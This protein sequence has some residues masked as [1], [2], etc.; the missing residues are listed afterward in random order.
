M[1]S[2]RFLSHSL[3]AAIFGLGLTSCKT[4]AERWSPAGGEPEPPA[5]FRHSTSTDAAAVTSRGAWWKTYRDPE[6]NRLMN[7]VESNNPDVKSALA[8]VEQAYATL[9]IT[10]A[11]RFP[12]LSGSAS[13]TQV[14]DS[15]NNLRFVLEPLKYEQYR[16]AANA[17]WELD[18]WGRVRGNFQRDQLRAEATRAQYDDVLLSLRATLARQYFALHYAR[19]EKAILEEGVSVRQEALRL[20]ETRVAEGA[21][22]EL[23]ASRART[24]LESTRVQAAELDRTTGKLEH[25]IAVL[26]GVAPADFTASKSQV[27]IR[28]PDTPSGIPSQ[29]L[30][31]R[32]DLRVAERNLH[33]AAKQVG[34]QKVEFLPRITLTGSG[35][36]ASLRTDNLFASP[37]SV[38]RSVG[39]QVDIPLFQGGARKAAVARVEAAWR[40]AIEDYRSTL[41]TAVQEVDD[42]LLDLQ[43][44]QRQIV[45]QERAVDS[46][47]DTA[48]LS[49][50]RFEQGF[51]SY[52]EVV[53]AE[54]SRLE[55]RRIENRLRGEKATTSVQLIQALGGSPD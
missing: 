39:P 17:S 42:S 10:G 19:R 55:A 52:F 48:R 15:A 2:L 18:L 37:E 5:T 32:P 11:E 44:L 29:L 28:I 14:K 41:L 47:N 1:T 6:L 12:R 9:G 20:Q 50:Q 4:V 24:E 43:V 7:R 3:T 21:G 8:R 27:G 38:F 54:R 51:V 25:A 34:I 45:S 49:K 30:V 16:I 35:G 53:D 23:D 40:E 13:S 22:V 33:A 36:V 31:R 26:T 46:A